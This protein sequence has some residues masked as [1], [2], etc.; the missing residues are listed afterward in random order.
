MDSD[1]S[2]ALDFDEF[3]KALI[4][5]KVDCPEEEVQNLFSIFDK[6]RD[7]TINLDEFVNAVLGELTPTRMS[8]V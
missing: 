2:G 3:S 8:L 7:G 1:G 6:N 5:Y 4:D